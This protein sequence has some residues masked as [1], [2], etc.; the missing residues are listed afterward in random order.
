MHHSGFAEAD[1][2][3]NRISNQIVRYR[4]QSSKIPLYD[5]MLLL[6]RIVLDNEFIASGDSY[7]Y[8]CHQIFGFTILTR[9]GG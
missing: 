2:H 4:I 9:S 8:S 5:E 3:H 1:E 7:K 6:S